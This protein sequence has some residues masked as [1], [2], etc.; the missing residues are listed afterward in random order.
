[1]KFKRDIKTELLV[2]VVK[3]LIIAVVIALVIIAIG[4]QLVLLVVYVPVLV[5]TTPA[6]AFSLMI[7]GQYKNP[8]DS[9]YKWV[10]VW[11]MPFLYWHN[12]FCKCAGIN[13]QL[14]VEKVYG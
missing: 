4:V 12:L 2:G 7:E 5:L 8:W 3:L 13:Q 9:E 14:D 1:M 11:S 10:R 6:F